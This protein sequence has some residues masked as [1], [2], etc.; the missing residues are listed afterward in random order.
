[1][2]IFA[3]LQSGNTEYFKFKPSDIIQSVKNRI[4]EKLGFPADSLRIIFDERNLDNNLKFS[5]YNIQEDSS[6]YL[7]Q[8]Q[9]GITLFEIN[10]KT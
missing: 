7:Y 3:Y 4:Q 9:P 5:D 6:L 10:P 8:D 2:H 1:M